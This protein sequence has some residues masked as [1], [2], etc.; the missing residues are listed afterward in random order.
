[1]TK[2]SSYQKL[3]LKIEE[4]EKEK[5]RL[6]K[7][8]Y[9]DDF[10]VLYG[11]KHRYG[12]KLSM[13]AAYMAGESAYCHVKHHNQT[14]LYNMI[15]RSKRQL[16]NLPDYLRKYPPTPD[17]CFK[18]NYYVVMLETGVYLAEWEGDPG[19]TIETKNAKQFKNLEDAMKA[20]GEAKAMRPFPH[21]CV[22]EMFNTPKISDKPWFK[23][24]D[25]V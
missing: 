6:E 23:K 24:D 16:D 21:A 10:V 25:N 19:R 3:K 20:M 1:M 7:A 13:D 2:I 14:G 5:H 11:V 4:L 22:M 17:E 12:L 9:E 8:I 18:P 15:V